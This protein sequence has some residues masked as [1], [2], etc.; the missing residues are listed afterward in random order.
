M[1]KLSSILIS[2]FFFSQILLAQD[3]TVSFPFPSVVTNDGYVALHF[4]GCVSVS[5]PGEPQIPCMF[6]NLL[7][8]QNSVTDTVIIKDIEYYDEVIT[9]RLMPAPTPQPRMAMRAT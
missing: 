9:G 8:A 3:V 5:E 6:Y 2:C 4:D 7:I 1:K